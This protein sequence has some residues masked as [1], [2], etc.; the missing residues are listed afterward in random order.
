[1]FLFQKEHVAPILEGT[2]TQTRRA[3]KKQRALPGKTHLAKT[4]ML[5]KEYFAR[6]LVNK[7]YQQRLGDISEEDA[8]AEG[9]P[10][11]A[12]YLDAFARINKQPTGD[13]FLDQT[14]YVIEFQL[15]EED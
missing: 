13:S 11:R 3:W 2:K 9:Y 12:D 7:V 10:S 14:V 1:M 4:K 15:I 6:L 5:S 8:K